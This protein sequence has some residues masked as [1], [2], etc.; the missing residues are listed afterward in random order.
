VLVI[1]GSTCPV[2]VAASLAAFFEREA[3]GQCPPCTVGTKNVARVVRLLAAGRAR[4]ADLATLSEAAGFMSGH[5][6]CAH[7]RTAA[8]SLTGL[9]GRFRADVDEHVGG[10]RRRGRHADPFGPDSPERSA[11]EAVVA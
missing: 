11:I 10:G 7:G 2:S 3:C 8:T 5:G 1:G 4:T 9:L 6:Y